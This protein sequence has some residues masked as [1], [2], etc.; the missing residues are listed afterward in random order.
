MTDGNPGDFLM[1]YVGRLGVEKRLKDIKP[2]LEQLPNARL[3]FVGIGP[4]EAELKEYFKD[5]NTVFMGLLRG[6]ELSKAF[7][8]ADIFMMPSDSET[9]GFVVLESMASGVPVV[10]CAAGGIQ[11][12]IDDGSTG[13]LVPPGDIK[14]FLACAEKL[15]DD[16]Y[17]EEMGLCARAEMEK[18][19]WEASMSYLRNVQ[20]DKALVNFHSRSSTFGYPLFTFIAIFILFSGLSQVIAFLVPVVL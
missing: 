12:L 1:I 9:L 4:H 19:G 11:D 6:D 14:G 13:F 2:V 15:M 10:G 17:R 3:C 16:T 8:S 18:W 7:A 20:Y 5:S